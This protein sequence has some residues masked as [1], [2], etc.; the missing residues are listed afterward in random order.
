MRILTLALAVCVSLVFAFTEWA[1]VDGDVTSQSR[2]DEYHIE[3]L[4]TIYNTWEDYGNTYYIS[5]ITGTY[6]IKCTCYYNQ[7]IIWSYTE[8]DVY[9][10]NED[11]TTVNFLQP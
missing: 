5:A 3:I 4:G 8:E 1:D 7:Q 11:T 9:L 10:V 2:C 6:D